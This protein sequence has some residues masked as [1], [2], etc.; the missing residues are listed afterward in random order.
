MK[1]FAEFVPANGL[2]SSRAVVS[3]A[4]LY[5][6]RPSLLSTGVSRA[7]IEALNQ[8]ASQRSALLIR[9]HRGYRKEIVYGNAHGCILL[10]RR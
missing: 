4:T 6:N 3:H 9:E 7:R 1:A 5:L 2:H 10:K 8:P